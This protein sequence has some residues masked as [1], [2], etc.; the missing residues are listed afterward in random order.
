MNALNMS[1]N[2]PKL[3]YMVCLCAVFTACRSS[4]QLVDTEVPVPAIRIDTVRVVETERVF[5]ESPCDTGAILDE[6]CKGEASGES[7]G[8]EWKFRYEKVARENRVQGVLIRRLADSV[9]VLVS[10]PAT[11]VQ[12]PEK[13]KEQIAQLQANQEAHGFWYFVQFAIACAF[14]GAVLLAVALVF[15]KF[16]SL[17]GL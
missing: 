16:K 7:D 12:I 10:K 1:H 13:L 14:T 3:A 4:V 5:V 9:H 6:L 2:M 8:V 17:F 15:T 11:T